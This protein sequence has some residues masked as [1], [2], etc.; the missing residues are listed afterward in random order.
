MEP[1][2]NNCTLKQEPPQQ[3]QDATVYLVSVVC[4]CVSAHSTHILQ[5]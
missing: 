4:V 2:L 5:Y 1:D 3:K